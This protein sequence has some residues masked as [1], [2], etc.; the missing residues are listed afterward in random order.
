[1]VNTAMLKMDPLFSGMYKA[2]IK[3]GRAREASARHASPSVLQHPLE[4]ANCW[5][6]PKATCCFARQAMVSTADGYAKREAAKVMH[7]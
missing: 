5:S 2:E 6:K 4:C 7:Q 1:M 3:G